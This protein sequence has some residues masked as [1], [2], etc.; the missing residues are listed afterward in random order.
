MNLLFDEIL[1]H[2]QVQLIFKTKINKKRLVFLHKHFI[3]IMK[4]DINITKYCC[5]QVLIQNKEPPSIQIPLATVTVTPPTMEES[6]KRSTFRE[7][8]SRSVSM[9]RERSMSPLSMPKIQE[10]HEEET[11]N[12][13][14]P[15]ISLTLK[16]QQAV[17]DEV[18]TSQV[19]KSDT[20]YDKLGL[21]I[22]PREDDVTVM[23]GSSEFML[24]LYP[25][26]HAKKMDDP[27]RK[28]L[29]I[30]ILFNWKRIFVGILF[31]RCELRHKIV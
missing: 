4:F 22:S 18:E 14:R 1:F 15:S 6:N 9:S 8:R 13:S 10:Q 30:T 24:V 5:K 7:S 11:F 25:E 28:N 19:T 31:L 21:P 17:V 3:N 29:G 2:I 23:H 26:D 12:Y 16:K 20:L 27:T